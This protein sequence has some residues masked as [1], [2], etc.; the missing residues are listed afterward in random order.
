MQ[1]QPYKLTMQ[2][3]LINNLTHPISQ[4]IEAQYCDTFWSRFQGLML[5]PSID[6]FQG[7]LLVQASESRIN[8]SIH[9]L[10]MKFDITAVW[11]NESNKVVD[12]QLALKW[13]PYYAPAS[14]AKF[15]L[16]LHKDRIKDFNIGDQLNY[17]TL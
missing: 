1:H 6:P 2:N 14:A 4:P 10:M 16:E 12:V 8:S 13:H 5:R 3:I 17:E 9:M 15:I 7:L 11:I